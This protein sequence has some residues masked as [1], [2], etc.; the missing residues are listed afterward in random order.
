MTNFPCRLDIRP[1]QANACHY[2]SFTAAHYVETS[3][4]GHCGIAWLTK[5]ANV[6]LTLEL[7]LFSY[8][9][10]SMSL[11]KR[12]CKLYGEQESIYGSQR[13]SVETHKLTLAHHRASSSSVVRASD[14]ITE[15]RGFKSHLGFDFFSDFSLHLI[16][17]CCFIF[18]IL[19]LEVDGLHLNMLQCDSTMLLVS[20]CVPVI[21]WLCSRVMRFLS[22]LAHHRVSSS[23]EVR[24]SE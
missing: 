9:G 22:R 18:N 16:S 21:T 5:E 1:R 23:S 11:R 2:A 8:P 13:E 17:C 15:G 24:A 7:H 19:T 14:W 3:C 4:A 6:T 10:E 20:S 12:H